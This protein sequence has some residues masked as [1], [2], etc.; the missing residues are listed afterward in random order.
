M[1]KKGALHFGH[2][3]VNSAADDTEQ[4]NTIFFSMTNY[5]ITT[6]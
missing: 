6:K 2:G 5:Y 3:L 1:E 4:L